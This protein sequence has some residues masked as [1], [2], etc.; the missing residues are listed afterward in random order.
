MADD[1]DETAIVLDAVEKAIGEILSETYVNAQVAWHLEADV[2]AHVRGIFYEL[3]QIELSD[4]DIDYSVVT[5]PD[6]GTKLNVS[7]RLPPSAASIIIEV[8]K[9][10]LGSSSVD[11]D[12]ES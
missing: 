10:P 2:K 8:A 1:R 6:E 3:G 9:V 7:V 5:D 12:P 4:D 11:G